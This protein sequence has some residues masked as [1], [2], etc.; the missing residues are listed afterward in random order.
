MRDAAKPATAPSAVET[1]GFPAAMPHAAVE[2]VR[3]R[4]RAEVRPAVRLH[5]GVGGAGEPLAGG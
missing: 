2:Q 1:I 4:E 5:M 3:A